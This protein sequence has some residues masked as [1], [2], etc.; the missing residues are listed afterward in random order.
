M[1][2]VDE[3][4]A[5]IRLKRFQLDLHVFPKLGVEGPERF[6][7]QQN[8]RIQHEAPR[9]GD[10][11]LLAARKLADL[12]LSRVRQPH[13]FENIPNLAIHRGPFLSSPAQ[14]ERDILVDVHHG[15]QREILKNQIHRALVR[16]GVPHIDSV[17]EDRSAVL[18]VETG[19]HPQQGGLAASRWSQYGEELPVLHIERD[20]IHG[21]EVRES[22]GEVLY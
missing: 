10:P 17:E 5:D 6:V 15:K 2:D 4:R 22:P 13:P 21:G 18:P 9:N 14:S 12:F 20:V 11:L 7:E 3:R 19:D 1:G 16:S 8:G